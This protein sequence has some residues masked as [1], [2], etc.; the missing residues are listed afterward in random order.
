MV[1]LRAMRAGHL[2]L[3]PFIKTRVRGFHR[4]SGNT[5][6]FAVVASDA[7]RGRRRSVRSKNSF[8]VKRAVQCRLEQKKGAKNCHQNKKSQA[9]NG[10]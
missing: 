3:A 10:G 7:R 8:V 5:G 1:L 2:S 4:F 6:R 9:D